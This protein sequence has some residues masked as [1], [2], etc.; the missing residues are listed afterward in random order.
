MGDK[1]RNRTKTIQR[2]VME[3][4]LAVEVSIRIAVATFNDFV[5][6]GLFVPYGED[7]KVLV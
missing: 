1:G 2:R 3:H 4:A 6:K 7:G 5:R